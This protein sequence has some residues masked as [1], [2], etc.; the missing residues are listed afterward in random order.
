M[1]W[2]CIIDMVQWTHRWWKNTFRLIWQSIHMHRN[3]DEKVTRLLEH[4]AVPY[5]LV[6]LRVW[7]QPRNVYKKVHL[8][9]LQ[10]G[11]ACT[12]IKIHPSIQFAQL[13]KHWHFEKE[14]TV[15]N[16]D[17]FFLHALCGNV[18]TKA[19]EKWRET[20][21]STKRKTRDFK[22]NSRI[23]TALNGASSSLPLF[24]RVCMCLY[25]GIE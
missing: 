20:K 23:D 4:T 24:V 3:R 7:N 5:L 13:H 9:T 2:T 17:C 11:H 1:V 10:R 12:Q 21:C 18:W 16:G 6:Y 15:T 14:S 22:S 19:D 25:F 8:E